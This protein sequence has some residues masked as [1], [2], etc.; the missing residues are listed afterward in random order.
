MQTK[1]PTSQ[2]AVQTKHPTSPSAVQTKN[3]TSQSA[4][5]TRTL[6]R[7]QLL[8]FIGSWSNSKY[9]TRPARDMVKHIAVLLAVG[10]IPSLLASGLGANELL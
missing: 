5:Q 3:P 8:S 2:S 4:V 6:F 7:T 1:H 9:V 10:R